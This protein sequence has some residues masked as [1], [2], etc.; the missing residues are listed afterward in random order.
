MKNLKLVWFT[1]VITFTCVA[2]K[3][4]RVLSSQSKEP[5][6]YANITFLKNDSISGGT[7]TN[8]EG[9][10]LLDLE[11]IT[12]VKISHLNFK[13]L[14]VGVRSIPDLI[15]LEDN[16]RVLEEVTLNFS[17]EPEVLFTGV[18]RLRKR[19]TMGAHEGFEWITLINNDF[20]EAKR[21]K[22]FVFHTRRWSRKQSLAM[23]VIFY[24]NSNRTPGEKLPVEVIFEL[25]R[26]MKK[27]V[28]IDLQHENLYLPEE[29]VFAGVEWIGCPYDKDA[30][31]DDPQSCSHSMV[32]VPMNE[33]QLKEHPTF[34][35]FR[36]ITEDWGSEYPVLGAYPV[37]AFG[38]EIYK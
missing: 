7:Y 12:T 24:S 16:P 29:G 6:P 30:P 27:E 22:S 21:I 20:G 10:A 14:S 33:E 28:I 2:Q 18:E 32:Y 3:E 11:G 19:H 38:L 17:A 26:K 35:R 8:A 23:K 4:V 31:E 37:P 36:Y 9:W 15:Y 34:S 5:V 1:L 25:D 13:E